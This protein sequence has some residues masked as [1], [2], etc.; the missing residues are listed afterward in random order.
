MSG[1]FHFDPGELGHRLTL[2]SAVETIDDDGV[3]AHD[4]HSVAD[5]WARLSPLSVERRLL[6][7]QHQEE[8]THEVVIRYREDVASGWQFRLGDRSFS[9]LHL[10][11]P[12]EQQRYLLCRCAEQAR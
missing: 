9:I 8:L 10:H 2:Q 1:G 3:V 7:Q 4:W 6:A 5:V 11:D 12:D